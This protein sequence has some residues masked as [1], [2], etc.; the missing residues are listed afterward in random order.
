MS[1][2][3][4]TAKGNGTRST[5]SRQLPFDRKSRGSAL[6]RIKFGADPPPADRERGH[7]L[8]SGGAAL[9][10]D[11]ISHRGQKLAGALDE[12]RRALRTS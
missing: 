2:D 7:E 4:L 8:T 12:L 11:D 6:I 3:R 10:E 9:S 5:A 1:I